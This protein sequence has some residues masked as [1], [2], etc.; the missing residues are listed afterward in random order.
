VPEQKMISTVGEQANTSAA[1]IPLAI[2]FGAKNHMFK[3]NQLLAL[4]AVGAGFA[5][6]ATLLRW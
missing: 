1:S 3:Q 6:G 4:T 5:W 2:D